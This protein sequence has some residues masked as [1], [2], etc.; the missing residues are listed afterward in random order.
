M[1]SLLV[2]FKLCTGMDRLPLSHVGILMHD[3]Y[4][5]SFLGIDNASCSD[6]GDFID[7]MVINALYVNRFSCLGYDSNNITCNTTIGSMIHKGTFDACS[8]A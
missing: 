3:S 8:M 2:C 1:Y 4:D 7:S 6:N 5:W